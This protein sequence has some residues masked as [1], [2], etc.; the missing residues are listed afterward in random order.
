[1]SVRNSECKKQKDR[2][3]YEGRNGG[4][5]QCREK[6]REGESAEIVMLT[7]QARNSFYGRPNNNC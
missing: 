6:G 2:E 4:D 1:V 7:G 5:L 3:G